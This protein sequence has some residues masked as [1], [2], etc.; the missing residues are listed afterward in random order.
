MN[1][2][3]QWIES[4]KRLPGD[5]DRRFDLVSRIKQSPSPFAD[6]YELRQITSRTTSD[7]QAEATLMT[8]SDRASFVMFVEQID[9]RY[10]NPTGNTSVKSKSVG[11][12]VGP[13][14]SKLSLFPPR[15]LQNWLC[16]VYGP[17]EPKLVIPRS[18]NA[19]VILHPDSTDATVEPAAYD[20]YTRVLLRFEPKELCERLGL[21]NAKGFPDSGPPAGMK[22]PLSIAG[23]GGR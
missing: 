4:L 7:T 15:T 6:I 18:Q 22:D 23:L 5:P 20:I 11:L 3:E 17:L 9:V 13:N 1:N 12:V 16:D 19:L 8:L 10:V 14:K 21:V 2:L